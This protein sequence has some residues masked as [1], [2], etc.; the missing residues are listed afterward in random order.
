MKIEIEYSDDSNL[1]GCTLLDENGNIVEWEDLSIQQKGKI[2]NTLNKFFELFSRCLI[3][4]VQDEG[5]I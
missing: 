1:A 3:K 4:N 2:V 5:N